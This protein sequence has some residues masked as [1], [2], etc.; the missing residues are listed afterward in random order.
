MWVRD[1][2]LF[3]S[4]D[5][6]GGVGGLL[7]GLQYLYDNL[8]FFDEESTDDTGADSSATE[9]STVGTGN[10]LLA[11]GV[12]SQLTWTTGFD[13]TENVSSVTAYWSFGGFTNSLVDESATWGLDNLSLV[14]RGVVRQS[15]SVSESLN[16]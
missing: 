11:F 3:P 10:G 5:L 7:L 14:G 8:L 1:I 16:H 4:L 13:T 2:R 6:L 12:L 9:G 15:S